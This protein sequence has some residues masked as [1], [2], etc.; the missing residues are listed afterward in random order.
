MN[1]R[2][3]AKLG[4]H[5]ELVLV[6]DVQAVDLRPSCAASIS[7]SDSCLVGVRSQTSKPRA[8]SEP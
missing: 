7:F 2:T 1:E 5:C 4:S 6:L 8:I 3:T